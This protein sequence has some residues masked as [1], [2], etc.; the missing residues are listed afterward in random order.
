MLAPGIPA[1]IALPGRWCNA[2][3]ML[4]LHTYYASM[5]SIR[6]AHICLLFHY[7][8][9]LSVALGA[10]DRLCSL[11]NPPFHG[12]V[13]M[14]QE[15]WPGRS[16]VTF[17]HLTQDY[18]DCMCTYSISACFNMF[19]IVVCAYHALCSPSN[20]LFNIHV[21]VL[22]GHRPGCSQTAFVH[23]TQN[24]VCHSSTIQRCLV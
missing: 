6:L 18:I 13:A 12:H 2:C 17:A 5:L 4:S 19:G 20:K 3:L 8:N 21:I 24:K 10:H 16:L 7:L 14:Q 23:A 22:Q 15:C 1:V 11:S 9:I